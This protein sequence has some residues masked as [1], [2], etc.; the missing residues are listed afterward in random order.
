M[1]LF[2]LEPRLI[3]YREVSIYIPLCIYFNFIETDTAVSQRNIYIPL[4]I[5]FN[6]KRKDVGTYRDDLHS[7]M[8]L[9]QLTANIIKIA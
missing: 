8:Y 5:Y 1:Y 7:T 3:P 9:F 2:Q 6:K 4:C